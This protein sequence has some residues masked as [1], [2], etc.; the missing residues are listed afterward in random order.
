MIV[1]HKDMSWLAAQPPLVYPAYNEDCAMG[2]ANWTKDRG[3]PDW[4]KT[5][6]VIG[7][8]L[9]AVW[10]DGGGE[11]AFG[12]AVCVATLRWLWLERQWFKVR[13]G[14]MR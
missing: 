14:K 5:S 8:V 2:E 11:A 7:I 12:F 13:R 6:I 1:P 3:I 10:W 4:V 9:G